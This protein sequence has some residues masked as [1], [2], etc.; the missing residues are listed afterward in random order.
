MSSIML[1]GG[2]IIGG[3]I[4]CMMFKDD[5]KEYT[6]TEKISNEE[7]TF[8]YF[9]NLPL[10]YQEKYFNDNL[11]LRYYK[12]DLTVGFTN[13]RYLNALHAAEISKRTGKVFNNINKTY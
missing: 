8:K 6:D 11:D 12:D 7:E 10:E 3:S 1:W 5:T 13:N 2:I 9:G 4:I